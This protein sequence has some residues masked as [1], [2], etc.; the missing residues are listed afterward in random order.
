MFSVLVVVSPSG[1]PTSRSRT[2]CTS[3]PPRCT[4]RTARRR[5]PCRPNRTGL[6]LAAQRPCSPPPS[7]LWVWRQR[8]HGRAASRP[9]GLTNFQFSS[10]PQEAK[11]VARA[12]CCRAW[13]RRRRRASCG[14]RWRWRQAGHA[15]CGTRRRRRQAGHACSRAEGRRG[16]QPSEAGRGGR[17]RVLGRLGRQRRRCPRPRG[18]RGRHGGGG[19]SGSLGVLASA[20]RKRG[21]VNPKATGKEKRAAEPTDNPPGSSRGHHNYPSPNAARPRPQAAANL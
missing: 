20:S 7:A 18:Q 8:V 6:E 19:G 12:C 3:L 2:L 17:R 10:V 13:W 14:P 9:Q 16:G 15:R 4:R 11:Q 21:A 1:R 5:P